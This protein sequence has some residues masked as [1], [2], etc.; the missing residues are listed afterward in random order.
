MLFAVAREATRREAISKDAVTRL[1]AELGGASG[2]AARKL[3]TQLDAEEKLAEELRVF[4]AEADRVAALGWEPDLD[5]GIILCAAPLADLFP[6]WPDAAKERTNL[7]KG[8]YPW[9]SVS[10]FA[11]DL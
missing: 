2:T 10:A 3:A 4:R 8:A 9:A 11:E 1:Q 6:A 7:R 5:D